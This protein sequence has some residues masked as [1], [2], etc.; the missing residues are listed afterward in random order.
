MFYSTPMYVGSVVN[1]T[2]KKIK[3]LLNGEV[4]VIYTELLGVQL[5]LINVFI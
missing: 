4:I 5:V 2:Q 3:V 1:V